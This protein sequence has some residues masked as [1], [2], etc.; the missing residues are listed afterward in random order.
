MAGT[1]NTSGKHNSYDG[2]SVWFFF[3]EKVLIARPKQM[4]TVRVNQERRGRPDS[5]LFIQL[6]TQPNPLGDVET[7]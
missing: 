6:K 1:P 7:L 4:M 2:N 3:G 5:I